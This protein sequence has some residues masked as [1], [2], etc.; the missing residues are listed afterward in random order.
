MPAKTLS[1]TLAGLLLAA[2]LGAPGASAGEVN[3]G[4]HIG[5]PAPAP[6]PIVLASPPRLVVV[7]GT[8]VLYAPEVQVNLFSL[9]GH[10]Y[11]LHGDTWFVAASHKGPWKVVHV[12]HVPRPL[13]AVPV[14]YY[15]IP[16]GHA[17]KMGGGHVPPGH[18][19]DGY[20][21]KGPKGKGKDKD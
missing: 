19:R 5:V 3:V 4:I 8:P 12:D 18:A 13:L 16:P 2:G 10:F 1:A 17:K 15:K 21:G 11:T 9:G 20:P 6:P 14:A 7:P